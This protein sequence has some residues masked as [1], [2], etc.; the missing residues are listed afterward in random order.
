MTRNID[1]KY[2]S[3]IHTFKHPP[4]DECDDLPQAPVPPLPQHLGEPPCTKLGGPDSSYTRLGTPVRAS[5]L[6]RNLCW[7]GL[8]ETTSQ[9]TL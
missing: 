8:M 2:I 5:M 3:L 6:A 7:A 9:N 1:L 4:L